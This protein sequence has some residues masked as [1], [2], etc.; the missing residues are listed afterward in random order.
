MPVAGRLF[1]HL[2][3]GDPLPVG[4]VDRPSHWLTDPYPV[5]RLTGLRPPRRDG[6]GSTATGQ[7]FSVTAGLLDDRKRVTSPQIEKQE[8]GSGNP[9]V[10]ARCW[11]GWRSIRAAGAIEC[12]PAPPH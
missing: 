6:N 3:T 8:T 12:Y 9:R 2:R 5:A 11:W 1:L 7:S 10:R 4:A